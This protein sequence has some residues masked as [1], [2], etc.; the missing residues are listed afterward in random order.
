MEYVDGPYSEILL[1]FIDAVFL[2][3]GEHLICVAA[4]KFRRG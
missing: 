4:I 1:Q 2:Q 3:P